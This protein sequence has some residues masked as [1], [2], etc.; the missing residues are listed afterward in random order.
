MRNENYFKL[1]LT[2]LLSACL[3]LKYWGL[4][5]GGLRVRQIGTWVYPGICTPEQKCRV[6][7]GGP[8]SGATSRRRTTRR[9]GVGNLNGRGIFF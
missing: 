7:S 1:R 6:F 8:R 9:L 3:G 5:G 2:C 4:G